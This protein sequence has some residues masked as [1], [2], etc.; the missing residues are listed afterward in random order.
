[1]ESKTLNCIENEESLNKDNKVEHIPCKQENGDDLFE[2][3]NIDEL[4]QKETKKIDSLPSS[5]ITLCENNV[6]VNNLNNKDGVDKSPSNANTKSYDL[7]HKAESTFF[8]TRSKL[9]DFIDCCKLDDLKQVFLSLNKKHSWVD[10]NQL[11]LNLNEKHKTEINNILKTNSLIKEESESISLK[12]KLAEE[13]LIENKLLAKAEI[14]NIFQEKS[15]TI[16]EMTTQLNKASTAQVNFVTKLAKK[17]KE[18]MN[19][20]KQ[21]QETQNLLKLSKKEKE[22]L[23][24][25]IDILQNDFSKTKSLLTKKEKDFENLTKKEKI[26]KEEL[27]SHQI[28]VKWAQNKLKSEID[29]HKATKDKCEKMNLQ[30]QQ[31]KEE[32]EQIRKN[33]QS[34]IK[35][36][37]ENEEIKSNSLDIKLKE[38]IKELSEKKSELDKLNEVL[39]LKTNEL[40]SLK[41]RNKDLVESNTLNQAKL[42]ILETEK[43]KN[44]QIVKTYEEVMNKQKLNASQLDEKLKFMEQ[45]KT[46]NKELKNEIGKLN[47]KLQDKDDEKKSIIEDLEKRKNKEQELLQFTQK[48]SSKNSE[49]T[50]AVDE[51]KLKSE[52]LIKAQNENEMLKG[53]IMKIEQLNKIELKKYNGQVDKISSQLCDKEIAMRQLTLCVE[54]QKDEIKTLKRKN[55]TKI[56]DL[57]KQLLQAR[58]KIDILEKDKTYNQQNQNYHDAISIS[59]RTSSVASLDKID[60]HHPLNSSTIDYDLI[61]NTTVAGTDGPCDR[62]MLIERI[63]RLQQLHAKKSEKI[64][65]LNEHAT[66]LVDELKKKQKIVEHYILREEAGILAPAKSKER[67]NRVKSNALTLDLSME[68]NRKMQSVLEDTILKNIT[69]KESLELMGKEIQKLQ[70]SKS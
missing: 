65:F 67:L 55:V 50:V 53:S 6:E 30:I 60:H 12:L 3:Q 58:K 2:K 28:K 19:I 8:E 11:I 14:Q 33:C 51:L 43:E 62:Q 34:M 23:S 16:K 70:T 4:V 1:M 39:L 40:C 31:A 13:K 20:Q 44:N 9:S 48:V 63:V 59:S 41:N 37:S 5:N 64:D 45:L 57:T 35:T 18:L 69:L 68:I 21:L 38:K 26:I 27:N 15:S 52:S 22:K 42:T 66:S 36:Y 49:L 61:P 56:K 10:I 17:E 32:T 24:N 29:S 46:E 25:Q 7:Q 47:E 54:E